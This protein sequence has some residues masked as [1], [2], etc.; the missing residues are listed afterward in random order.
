L[1]IESQLGKMRP[2]QSGKEVRQEQLQEQQGCYMNSI[3]VTEVKFTPG[4]SP[5]L[6]FADLI[7]NNGLAIH[8]VR[9]VEHKG[10]TLVCMPTRIQHSPCKSCGH[11]NP[12]SNKFCGA[13]RTPFA[14]PQM[15]RHYLDVIHPI[16][17]TVRSSIEKEVLSAYDQ[18]CQESGNGLKVKVAA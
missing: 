1:A 2:H 13:C 16:N 18:F 4:A 7:I 5:V 11:K 15:E 14:A 17:S 9:L 8:G 3:K 12:V 10:K 6:A